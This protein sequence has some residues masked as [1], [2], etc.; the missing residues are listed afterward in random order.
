MY[1]PFL[2]LL[3]IEVPVIGALNGHA[4]GGGFGLA[5]VCDLRIG[6]RDAQVRRELRA[7]SASRPGW[8]SATC[9]RG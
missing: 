8:R 7:G 2:S 6:A 5:L 1:E 4:V 3:D 9:C